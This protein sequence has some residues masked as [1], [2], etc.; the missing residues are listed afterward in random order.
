MDAA[1]IYK[2]S[3]KTGFLNKPIWTTVVIRFNLAR[4]QDIIV[5]GFSPHFV[6]KEV[7]EKSKKG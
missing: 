1:S 6:G 3:V 4:L 2:I 5:K 7:K